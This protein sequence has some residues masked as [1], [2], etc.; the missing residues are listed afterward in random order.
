MNFGRAGNWGTPVPKK[1][2]LQVSQWGESYFPEN[3]SCAVLHKPLN[4]SESLFPHPLK[5]N[6]GTANFLSPLSKVHA[7]PL[8][9]GESPSLVHVHL[10]KLEEI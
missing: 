9:F 6:S 7:P 10:H 4:L 5:G 1:Y 8:V 2:L 3:R